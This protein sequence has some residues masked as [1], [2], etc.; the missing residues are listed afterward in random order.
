MVGQIGVR[1][2]A[3]LLS[4]Q[5]GNHCKAIIE[6]YL[7]QHVN[8]GSLIMKN[9]PFKNQNTLLWTSLFWLVQRNTDYYQAKYEGTS[10]HGKTKKSATWHHKYSSRTIW[11]LAIFYSLNNTWITDRYISYCFKTQMDPWTRVFVRIISPM[12]SNDLPN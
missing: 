3:K 2:K 1:Q 11:I 9:K 6:S 5:Y 4:V 8:L 7:S 12:S 10:T